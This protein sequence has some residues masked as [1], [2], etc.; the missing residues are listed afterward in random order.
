LS[1]DAALDAIVREVALLG[2][3]T[4]APADAYGRVTAEP[5]L[6]RRDVPPFA[7][8]AMD[9]FVL[10]SAD[11]RQAAVSAPARLIVERGEIAAGAAGR[12]LRPGCAIRIST[13]GAIPDGAD[14]VVAR[15]RAALDDD[16]LVIVE[17]CDAGRNVRPAGEDFAPGVA[18]LEAGMPVSPAAIGGMVASGVGALAVRRR[19][20]VALLS[21]GSEFVA[22]GAVAV[23]SN[24]PMI[25]ALGREAGVDIDLVGPV[26]DRIE[27]IGAVLDRA[28]DHD[29]VLSSGG[30]SGG[31]YDLVRSALERR[32]ARVVFHGLPMRP[33]KP[34]LFAILADGR[35][36]IGLPGNPVAAMVGFR[37]FVTAA[38]RAMLGLAPERG[39]PVDLAVPV[40]DGTTLFLRGRIGPQRVGARTVD[41]GLNQ[42]SH[43]LSSV[44]AADCWLRCDLAGGTPRTIAYPLAALLTTQ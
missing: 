28:R 42:R 31:D 4:V 26:A 29:L 34:I 32:G 39:E 24:G 7:M 36:F 9:G 35:P 3:E 44:I 19:P 20:R 14:C 13:G 12:T 11:T 21:T 6:A 30:V 43:V 23:D 15:E 16:M 18:V 27:A 25:R 5:V 38:L 17:P 37:F 2:V 40:R 8:S 41:I 22:E 1:V 33:G 10:R